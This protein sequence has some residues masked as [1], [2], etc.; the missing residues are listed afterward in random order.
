MKI[1]PFLFENFPF[2]PK[3][4]HFLLKNPPQKGK[5]RIFSSKIQHLAKKSR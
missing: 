1:T 3:I 4:T 2:Y 5:S